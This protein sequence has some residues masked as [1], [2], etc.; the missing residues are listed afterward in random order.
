MAA[1]ITMP[2]IFLSYAGY[3]LIRRTRTVDVDEIDLSNGPA[4]ALLNT[5]YDAAR[6]EYVATFE[7]K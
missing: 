7:N 3:K 6:S 5:R 1:Y 2:I 4:H